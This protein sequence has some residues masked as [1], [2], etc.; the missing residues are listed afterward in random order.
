MAQL[1]LSNLFRELGED[2]QAAELIDSLAGDVNR[3]ADFPGNSDAGLA[4]AMSCL[5]TGQEERAIRDFESVTTEGTQ[6]G[7]FHCMTVAIA[8]FRKGDYEGALNAHA[9]AGKRSRAICQFIPAYVRMATL[10][11]H[12]HQGL[13]SEFRIGLDQRQQGFSGTYLLFDWTVL[14]MLGEHDGLHEV[15]QGFRDAYARVPHREPWV[16]IADYMLGAVSPDGLVDRC[17]QSRAAK[18]YAHF[19]VAIDMLA[20][21][22]RCAARRHFEACVATHS[23]T[24]YS[25]FWSLAFLDRLDDPQWLP[26][27]PNQRTLAH[28]RK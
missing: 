18:S 6:P 22:D 23:F 21:G 25:Y 7:D 9:R 5:L 20:G 14:R 27:L 1:V 24:Y 4:A 26:W 10:K 8:Y 11:T 28:P 12:E 3:L 13:A 16:D 17:Q 2:R 15:A 19:V